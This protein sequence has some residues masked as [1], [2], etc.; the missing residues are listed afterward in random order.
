MVY[1]DRFVSVLSMIVAAGCAGGGLLLGGAVSPVHADYDDIKV[2]EMFY[3]DKELVV[4]PTRDPKPISQVAENVTVITAREIQALNAH[5]L[6]EVL[7]TIP[8]VHVEP[9]VTPGGL[10]PTVSVQGSESN[11]V[12]VIMDGV[13][14]NNVSDFLADVGAIPVQRIA[15]VEIIKGPASS[16]WGSSLG[17]IINIITKSPDATRNMG[18]MVSASMGERTTGDFRL[19]FSG[20]RSSLGYYLTADGITSDGLLPHTNVDSGSVYGKLSWEPHEDTRV[21][22]TYSYSRGERGLGA[23]PQLG[24]LRDGDYEYVTATL[25]LTHALTESLD[26]DISGRY[27][28]RDYNDIYSVLVPEFLLGKTNYQQPNLGASAKIAWR[29]SVHSINLGADYDNATVDAELIDNSVL[30]PERIETDGRLERWAIFA[31]DTIVWKGLS[32]T[33]GLRYDWTNTN[34]EFLSPSLGMTYGWGDHTVLRAYV[35][36]GFNIPS[37]TATTTGALRLDANPNLKVEKVWSYQIGLE[38][39]LLRYVW[40]KSTLFRHDVSNFQGIK[41]GNP[42]IYVNLGK[43]YREG[44]EVEAK[45]I[46]LFNTTLSVGYTF[47]D[48]HGPFRDT[49]EQLVRGEVPNIPRHTFDASISYDDRKLLRGGL[50]GRYVQWNAREDFNS[51]DSAM[52]WDLTGGIRVLST[53]QVTGEV[54]VV[55]HNLFNGSQYLHSVLRNPGRWFEGGIRLNF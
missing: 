30:I 49:T 55:A 27:S 41:T 5:T 11:H 48:A 28:L 26:L 31:N 43:Q 53:S 38:T 15:A 23:F 50:V 19:E 3:E 52:I 14:I 10:S 13:T 12:R 37:L 45:T 51:R 36:K 46:P 33:P 39:T 35:A 20:T 6:A 17:G 25:G 18:G 1:R 32:I 42:D 16:A 44:V 22:A 8:G 21:L 24:Y 34:G 47:I 7:N 29:T 40:V 9:R 54:F 2:L 4:T